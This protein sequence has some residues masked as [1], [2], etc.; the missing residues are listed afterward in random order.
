M[1]YCIF[2]RHAGIALLPTADPAART[3]AVPSIPPLRGR[4]RAKKSAFGR[5][6]L[7]FA[8]SRRDPV[9]PRH[10]RAAFAGRGGA[11]VDTDDDA[12]ALFAVADTSHSISTISSSL[13]ELVDRGTPHPN[14]LCPR[15]PSTPNSFS[16]S[17]PRP[18]HTHRPSRFRYLD[19]PQTIPRL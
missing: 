19:T 12:T 5:R 17:F 15:S 11:R 10:Y 7:P 16:R 13:G 14:P 2:D 4:G 6:L 1:S 18:S 8:R 9:L 3:S